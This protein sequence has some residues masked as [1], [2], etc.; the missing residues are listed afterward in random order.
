VPPSD[1]GFPPNP[2]D[3][4]GGSRDDQAAREAANDVRR[5]DKSAN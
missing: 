5:Q 4:I 3:E 2:G 1:V